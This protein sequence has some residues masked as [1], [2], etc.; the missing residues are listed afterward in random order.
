MSGLSKFRADLTS[1]QAANAELDNANRPQ[2]KGRTAILIIAGLLLCLTAL[3][4][5]A[6]ESPLRPRT[7]DLL[8]S[9]LFGIAGLVGA[10]RI[11]Y[12]RKL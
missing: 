8:Q 10:L 9:V 12:A 1:Y 7:I 2:I 3:T 4:Y 11:R 5:Y 6:T